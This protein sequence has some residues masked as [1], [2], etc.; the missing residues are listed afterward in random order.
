MVSMVFMTGGT[1]T[2]TNV[3][4]D[5]NTDH[6]IRAIG[7]PVVSIDSSEFTNNLTGAAFSGLSSTCSD[8]TYSSQTECEASGYCDD[9]TYVDETDCVANLATWTAN[10]WTNNS[11]IFTVTNSLFNRMLNPVYTSFMQEELQTHAATN[12]QLY[13]MECVNSSFDSCASNSLTGNIGG[14]QTGCD[15]TCGVEAN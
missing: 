9:S 15:E 10:T 6:G 4:A 5:S 7:S 11:A 8:A 1:I 2:G 14:E 13:G 3:L 12:N